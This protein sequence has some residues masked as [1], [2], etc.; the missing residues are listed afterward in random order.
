MPKRRR[1]CFGNNKGGTGKT[2]VTTQL[3]AVM[4]ARERRV[5]VIDMDPQAN[6][7]RRL[8]FNS[9]PNN[10][11]P[12]IAEALRQASPGLA[13]DVIVPCGWDH[14]VAKRID[15][16]PSSYYLENRI[17]EAGVIGAMQRLDVVLD[18]VDD[19]YDLVL[20]DCPP[21]LG[22]LTQMSLAASDHA[23]VVTKP[24][25]DDVQGALR[26]Y[27][28]VRDNAAIGLGNPHLRLR[29]VI[30]DNYDQR[31]AGHKFQLDGLPESFADVP[32]WDPPIPA[33][34]VAKDATDAAAPLQAYGGAARPREL[35]EKM[36]KLA[37]KLD[38]L[39]QEEKAA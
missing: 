35:L 20:I 13:A 12:T 36:N 16:I 29:G 8:G 14:E 2:F 21:S 24:E 31:I 5:L 23:L 27:S 1:V 6:A 30:V 22:H 25:Y 28:F 34:A 26:Y 15:L 4:S 3:A 37:E 10:P 33:W 19:E 32:I 11:L 39:T 7:T 18:G 17:S 9:D 38:E